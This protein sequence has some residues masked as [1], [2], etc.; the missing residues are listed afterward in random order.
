MSQDLCQTRKILNLVENPRNRDLLLASFFHPRG[1]LSVG[2]SRIETMIFG[3]DFFSVH[4]SR[5]EE[6][7]EVNVNTT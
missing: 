3:Q 5:R 2:R 1:F 4:Q 6:K 7:A